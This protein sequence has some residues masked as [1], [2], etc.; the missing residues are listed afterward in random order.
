[1]NLDGLSL[2]QAE[3]VITKA[4]EK[5]YV[6]P[7]IAVTVAQ[8]RAEPVSVIGAIGMPGVHEAQGRTTLLE[9]LSSAG[10]V[11]AD[12]GPVVKITRQ[13]SFGPIPLANA[14][15][16]GGGT[17]VAEVDLRSLIEARNPAESISVQPY[18]SRS[19]FPT[20]KVVYI[21]GN[22]KKS[23]KI[24]LGGR[25]SISALEVLSMAEG[26]DLKAALSHAR[27]MR[28]DST[29]PTAERKRDSGQSCQD[30]EWQ[31]S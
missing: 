19:Q 13:Q 23:G 11:R 8:F 4:I 14:R 9:M 15:D 3:A 2:V 31:E 7:D 10:G 30:Y 17:T 1:M 21:V 26:L 16:A 12:A 5:Y 28:P 29:A 27:I 24:P 25:T 18:G 22:V 6:S 20:P